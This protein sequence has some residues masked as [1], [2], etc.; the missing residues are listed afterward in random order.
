MEDMEKKDNNQSKPVWKIAAA[1]C[2]AL[3][4]ICLGIWGI[5][6][7]RQASEEQRLAQLAAQTTIPT[8]TE[9]RSEPSPEP[10]SETQE[11]EPESKDNETILTEMGVPIP[12]K[13]VDFETLQAETNADIYAWI[14]LPDSKI[15]YPVLQHPSNNTYYLEYNLDGS[16]GYPGCIYT[17]N[18]NKKDFS[19]PVTVMYGHNMKSGAMFAGLHK[20]E[21]A[22]YFEEHPYVYVYTPEKLLVYQIFAAAVY[23]DKHILLNYDF[24]VSKA[25]DGFMTEVSSSKGMGN[26]YNKDVEVT[27]EDHVLVMSTCIAS[28]PNNRYIVLGVL[29][30]ED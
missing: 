20:F 30:N 23:S 22:Q 12:E 6:K 21:D 24:T 8:E 13:S 4:V 11:T 19:D 17:E 15:D 27:A 14:Y 29:L 2:V 10:A 1:A 26:N 28:K 16:K 3:A 25:F 5:Q 9:N 18:Y 7:G